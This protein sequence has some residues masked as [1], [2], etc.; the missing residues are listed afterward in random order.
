MGLVGGG[1]ELDH[2]V[3]KEDDLLWLPFSL[4]VDNGFRKESKRGR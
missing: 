4:F 3:E 1:E 2:E